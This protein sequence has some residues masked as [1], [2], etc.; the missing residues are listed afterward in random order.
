M[1]PDCSANSLQILVII[2]I[3]LNIGLAFI[4]IV[5]NLGLI[6]TLTLQKFVTTQLTAMG[7]CFTEGLKAAEFAQLPPAAV[8]VIA[9]MGGVPF[10]EVVRAYEKDSMERRA[11]V[12][13]VMGRNSLAKRF[14]DDYSSKF[15]RQGYSSED[16]IL[17]A[18]R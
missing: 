15:M 10:A 11:I 4:V 7:A 17:A 16:T 3:L 2:A 9:N 12:Y 8:A 18:G 13:A 6:C 1:E 14:V 5:L